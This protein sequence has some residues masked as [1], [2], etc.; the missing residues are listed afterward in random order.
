MIRLAMLDRHRHDGRRR[1]R[2]LAAPRAGAAPAPVPAFSSHI[3]NSETPALKRT[4]L[5]KRRP[6]SKALPGR[7]RPNALAGDGRR[8]DDVAGGQF[9]VVTSDCPSPTQTADVQ[10]LGAILVTAQAGTELHK[11]LCRS[12]ATSA[13]VRPD[14]TVTHAGHELTKV[15]DVL[16]AVRASG[17]AS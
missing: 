5:V 17:R 8:F 14:G 10:R 3:L 1:V 9:S 7:L 15:C 6:L 16:A 11:W 2:Q 12:K 4:E 13:L